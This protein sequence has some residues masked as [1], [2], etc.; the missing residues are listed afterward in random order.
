MKTSLPALI[1]EK[2]KGW[3]GFPEQET[4]IQ[5]ATSSENRPHIRT[6]KLYEV[7]QDGSCIVLSHN[8]TQKWRDLQVSPHIA[9][10][11]VNY[12]FGQ[13]VVEGVAR[14]LTKENCQIKRYWECMP[15][16]IQQIYTPSSGKEISDHFGVISVQPLSW[17]ILEINKVDYNKSIR[18]KFVPDNGSWKSHEIKP[19]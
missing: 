9:L 4:H 3:F 7:T 1:N 18:R 12:D 5:V 2:L 8:K 16:H 10:L 15:K 13:L 6:M 17:E 19:V 11:F 14:L